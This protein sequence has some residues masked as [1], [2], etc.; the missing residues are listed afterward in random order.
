MKSANPEGG[1]YK[2][3]ALGKAG[4]DNFRAST[5]TAWGPHVHKASL[6][7]QSGPGT[8]KEQEGKVGASDWLPECQSL[9]QLEGLGL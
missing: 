2:G 5:L 1:W 7:L 9:N 6:G 4:T 8:G 3:W